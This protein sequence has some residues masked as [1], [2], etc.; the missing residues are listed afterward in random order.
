[1]GF[2]V[3][4]AM[5]IAARIIVGVGCGISTVVVPMFLGEI[6][7]TNY[8]GAIGVLL[9]L[10]VTV[11]IMVSQLIGLALSYVPGWRWL[12]SLTFFFCIVQIVFL[13][14]LTQTPRVSPPLLP[15]SPP[16]CSP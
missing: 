3:N 7:P 2:A 4:E 8:R 9:Q 1:M 12:V 5:L 13:P 6:S 14:F 11:G 16:A 10:S 15:P